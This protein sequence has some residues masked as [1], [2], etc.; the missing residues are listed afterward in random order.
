MAIKRVTG[1][2]P[3]PAS[4]AAEAET[5]ATV[6]T[7][8][9]MATAK[10]TISIKR[11][12]NDGTEVFIAPGIELQGPADELDATQAAV[13]ERVN[14]WLQE[15]LADYP[16]AAEGGE[17]AEEEAA[18]EEE[19]ADEEAADE[20]EE[21]GVTEEEIRA[22][23]LADLKAFIKENELEIETKGLKLADLR[24]AVIEALSGDEDAEEEAAEDEDAD[25]EAEEE[26]EGVSEDD[27]KKM[28]LEELQALCE[29]WE[30]GEPE[31]KKGAALPAKKAAYIKHIM[32][33]QTE[34]E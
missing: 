24:E 20:D 7:G 30:I 10:L 27:L 33:A 21:E 29:E 12:L 22:M 17:E 34:E 4:A 31:V 19:A 5:T 13:A 23:S 25:E 3:A 9:P 32:A 2:K 28:K 26:A 11:R 8:A 15:L 18:E 16:D 6:S 1:K 14:G